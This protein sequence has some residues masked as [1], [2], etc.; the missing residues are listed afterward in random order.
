MLFLSILN[1]SSNNNSFLLFV[2]ILLLLRVIG[3]H[4]RFMMDKLL[5]LTIAIIINNKTLILIENV[6]L[7]NLHLNIITF[8]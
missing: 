8:V 1:H 2:V 7:I 6:I 5:S 3:S 4:W